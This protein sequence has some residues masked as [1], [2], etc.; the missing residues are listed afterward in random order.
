MLPVNVLLIE[1]NKADAALVQR[2]LKGATHL[3]FKVDAV[4]WLSS[5]LTALQNR[6]YDVILLD[7]TLPDS[8]G[9]DTVIA[10]V[11]QAPNIPVIV[12]SGHEDLDTAK[13]SVRAGAQSFIVKKAE[14]TADELEREVLYAMERIRHEVTSKQ[15]LRESMR[16]VS[17]DDRPGSEP[18]PSLAGVVSEHVVRIEETLSEIRAY[19]F[20][21][22]PLAHEGVESILAKNSMASVLM[23][24]RSLL[25]LD[26]PKGMT[27]A[28]RANRAIAGLE[29]TPPATVADAEAYLLRFLEKE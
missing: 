18:P 17:F 9:I 1:D 2:R 14:F 21:N 26:S 28:E 3:A 4:E 23:E 7:L 20:K 8:T 13:N 27:T 11:R 29:T 5:G 15:L 22:Y 10:V 12:L 16:R 19:L 6:D 25:R 24:M